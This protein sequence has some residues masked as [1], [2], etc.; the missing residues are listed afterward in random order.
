MRLISTSTYTLREFRDG[1]IP[2]HA[3]LSHVWGEEEVTLQDVVGSHAKGKQG[4]EKLRGFCSVAAAN[5]FEYAWIDS[6][7]IDKTSS[8]ELSEAI[9]SMYY[10][11]EEADVC[12][13][14]LADVTATY[15]MASSKW[16]TRGWTLQELIAPRSMIFYD[17]DWQVLGTKEE[18]GEIVSA[19]TRIPRSILSGEEDHMSQS[20]A[21]RMSWASQRK[22]TRIEDRAYSLLGIFGINM[23][24]IYGER[25]NAFIRLQEE[26][27]R[28]SDD[29]TIF[30][31]R[32]RDQRGGLLAT[33][34]DAFS[35]SMNIVRFGKLDTVDEPPTSNSRG[36]HLYV[37][38]LGVKVR[39]VGLAILHCCDTTDKAKPI[40][41]YVRDLDFKMK[42]FERFQS[43]LTVPIDLT[44]FSPTRFS[45][46][47]ICVQRGNL[48]RQ[49]RAKEES[50]FGVG[51]I[52]NESAEIAVARFPGTSG[53]TEAAS[54]GHSDIVWLLLTLNDIEAEFQAGKLSKVFWAA[55]EYGHA[56]VLEVLV[57]RSHFTINEVAENDQGD[58][59]LIGAVKGGSL[60]AVELLLNAGIELISYP[61][62][63]ALG[64]AVVLGRE[65]MVRLLVERGADIASVDALHK[66]P[67]CYAVENGRTP[68][69]R[70]LL[71]M[72][73]ASAPHGFTKKDAYSRT[74]L[75][76]AS[77]K[78][79][80]KIVCMLLP[81][82]NR[83]DLEMPNQGLRTPLSFA[84]EIGNDSV[85]KCL[86]DSGADPLSR[87]VAG[88]SPLH[89][90]VR[91]GHEGVVKLL[92]E[93]NVTA[94]KIE[95]GGGKTPFYYAVKRGN[96][97]L[98]QLLVDMGASVKTK[99]RLAKTP[100]S[101]AVEA[102]DG[103]MAEFLIERGALISDEPR[104]VRRAYKNISSRHDTV[105][106]HQ[107]TSSKRFGII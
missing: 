66:T 92:I 56:K 11:Y 16:F 49:R 4:Y 104:E 7:C 57:G 95:D 35:D 37:N 14:Y 72:G 19:C 26:I 45:V 46:R 54:A 28:I 82:C 40:A 42:R 88:R 75:S 63:S 51:D 60:D 8:A 59:L 93:K 68:V 67:L 87:D 13:A 58:S 34:P 23:S 2:R 71:E 55:A 96:I 91:D 99:D 70:L 15:E 76:Y 69:V 24:L 44:S 97:G 25:E 94:L 50:S 81:T 65:D 64:Y 85:V 20:V 73:A 100:L 79:Y 80:V 32:S 89:F 21:Q 61:R 5:G 18:L 103:E 17:K 78:G 84:A 105:T 90:A 47:H 6:A 1:E 38:Y 10:W 86:L 12:Y 29:Q 31:W 101:Y 27:M 106:A 77:E 62:Q 53:F 3:I 107:R 36:I 83:E 52:S 22:T 74:P 48:L 41:I 43:H 30:A 39:G 102:N 98:A 9:N 33:S